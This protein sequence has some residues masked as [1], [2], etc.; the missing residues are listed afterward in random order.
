[1]LGFVHQCDSKPRK[2]KIEEKEKKKKKHSTYV[3]FPLS[4]GRVGSIEFSD[5]KP[6]NGVVWLV[7]GK[8]RNE[9]FERKG[10]KK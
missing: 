9:R 5:L 7:G 1:M 2:E 10:K 6:V 3:S 8:K 4:Q